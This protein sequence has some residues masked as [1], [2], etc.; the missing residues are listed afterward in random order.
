MIFETCFE[1][2]VFICQGKKCEWSVLIK[3]NSAWTGTESF[4]SMTF[5]MNMEPKSRMG[6]G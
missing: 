6:K 2:F 1:V 4:G 5:E 3:R